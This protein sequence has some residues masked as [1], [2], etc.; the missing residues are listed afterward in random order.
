MTKKDLV[1]KINM[2]LDCYRELEKA[3]SW[4]AVDTTIADLEDLKLDI[5]ELAYD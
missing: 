3:S 2:L 5:M 4:I 1:L